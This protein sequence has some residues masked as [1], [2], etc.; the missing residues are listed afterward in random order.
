MPHITQDRTIGD[1]AQAQRGILSLTYPITNGIVNNWDDF[2]AILAH[3]YYNELKV[4]PEE[5]YTLFTEPALNPI[6]NREKLTQIAFET[7]N[8][9]GISVQMGAVLSSFSSGRSQGMMLDSGDGVTHV[10]PIYQGYTI[11]NAIQ[12]ID[13]GGR[14][15]TENLARILTESG[16]SLINPS[17]LENAREI[18][19][20]CAYVAVDYQEELLKSEIK[21]K[22]ELPDGR[23]VFMSGDR[24]RCAEGLFTP[25]MFG[26]ENL[27]IHEL[28]YSSIMKCD[29]DLRSLFYTSI[30]LSGGNTMLPNF[31]ERLNKELKKLAPLTMKTQVVAPPERKFSAWIGGAKITTFSAYNDV[32]WVSSDE[33][34]ERGPAAIN[35]KC[36]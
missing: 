20:K 30:V 35:R 32:I 5:H 17:E 11:R 3:T 13:E 15:V 31:A 14:S 34:D 33:Y 36:L 19:E 4:A 22:Y 7:F 12:R 24:F 1:M 29:I 21:E 26:K 16:T 23:Y 18:K 9:R 25:S 6:A 27:G 28:V 2:E 10:V 8:S